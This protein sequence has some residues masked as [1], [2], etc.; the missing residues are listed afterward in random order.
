MK[1]CRACGLTLYCADASCPVCGLQLS[2]ASN[3]E[4]IAMPTLQSVL[5]VQKR[6]NDKTLRQK[7]KK[8]EISGIGDLT[9]VNVGDDLLRK[10]HHTNLRLLGYCD[11]C[12]RFQP[13]NGNCRQC[14]RKL[15]YTN[16]AHSN[17]RRKV[18]KNWDAMLSEVDRRAAHLGI[19]AAQ[20]KV[21]FALMDLPKELRAQGKSQGFRDFIVQYTKGS[22][23][24]RLSVGKLHEILV[25][26]DESLFF[27]AVLPREC[28]SAKI[29]LSELRR[30]IGAD[31]QHRKVL[32]AFVNLESWE[33]LF[34]LYQLSHT[35]FRVNLKRASVVMAEIR[36]EEHA[37]KVRLEHATRNPEKTVQT[38]FAEYSAPSDW[39]L[40]RTSDPFPRKGNAP[41]VQ[42]SHKNRF[43][44]DW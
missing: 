25:G 12:E 40:N 23:P 33:E 35:S 1:I 30:Y 9:F 42:R 36:A 15:R 28:E 31:V 43:R 41:F 13:G 6:L 34:S 37:E 8:S 17:A 32:G 26:A 29:P 3:A 19:T 10:F 7:L 22:E 27:D 21:L 18:T 20:I 39:W 5:K 24:A 4:I 44:K 2:K 14:L 11:F 38:N 16:L